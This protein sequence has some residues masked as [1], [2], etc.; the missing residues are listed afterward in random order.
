MSIAKGVV[1]GRTH[2]SENSSFTIDPAER[3]QP[4]DT[5][6]TII[7]SRG[8]IQLASL[9]GYSPPITISTQQVPEGSSD[10]QQIKPE[11][12][13]DQRTEE[14]ATKTNTETPTSGDI[15]ERH[16]SVRGEQEPLTTGHHT[17]QSVSNLSGMRERPAAGFET[18]NL[19]IWSFFTEDDVSRR[20]HTLDSPSPLTANPTLISISSFGQEESL[21]D[22][23]TIEP[24][25]PPPAEPPLP[26]PPPPTEPP[27][28]PPPP[29]AEPPLPPP[30]PPAEPPLP[31]P[32]DEEIIA[33]GLTVS[34]S[35]VPEG[36]DAR[37]T[38]TLDSAA[39]ADVPVRLSL[40]DSGDSATAGSD[41]G[42]IKQV[43]YTDKGG[44]AHIL[45]VG[46]DGTVTVPYH[47][48][49]PLTFLLWV[50]MGRSLCLRG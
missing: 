37:F 29:P 24:P 30:P 34:G 35:T 12:G 39:E 48:R 43:T 4:Q 40:G 27:L 46:D 7:D 14:D 21:P 25:P 45:V 33:P 2:F 32:P 23:A 15:S 6:R 19:S 20:S 28:P 11:S 31:P 1:T 26:P 47:P 41:Y 13:P 16:Q 17:Y 3:L 36:S 50:M 9:E 5:G 8:A 49:D 18:N 10:D 44:S 38:V 22:T 42:P